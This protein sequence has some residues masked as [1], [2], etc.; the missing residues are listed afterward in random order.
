MLENLWIIALAVLL[1][2]EF[3]WKAVGLWYSARK[4]DKLWFA[5]ILIVN[6]AGLIPIFYL[7][8]KT[9]FFASKKTKV[10]TAKKKR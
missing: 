5:V 9:D 6:M 2:W 8:L 4:N 1:I 7:G 3:I 10:K